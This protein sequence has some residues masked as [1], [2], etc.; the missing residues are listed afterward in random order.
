M[1]NDV[2]CMVTI[3]FDEKNKDK[4][5]EKMLEIDK[6]F[7]GLFYNEQYND[8]H[9]DFCAYGVLDDELKKILKQLK[10]VGVTDITIGEYEETGNNWAW[11][12]SDDEYL[13]NDVVKLK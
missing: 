3:D 2:L 5:K 9:I 10:D 1:S 4:V 8:T 11:N 7:G 13:E 12:I 6:S